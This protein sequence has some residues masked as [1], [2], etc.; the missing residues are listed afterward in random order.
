MYAFS[1]TLRQRNFSVLNCY[2]L[3]LWWEAGGTYD[4]GYE[5]TVRLQHAYVHAYG[6]HWNADSRTNDIRFSCKLMKIVEIA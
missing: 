5:C 4:W 3:E 6:L 1:L 2:F